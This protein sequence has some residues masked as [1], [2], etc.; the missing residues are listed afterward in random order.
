MDKQLDDK[1]CS[2]FPQLFR[3]RHADKMTTCMYWGFECDSGWEPLI[4]GLSVK[5]QFLSDV[6]GVQVIAKQVKNKLGTLRFYVGV[7]SENA[8]PGSNP[9]MVLSI[10]EDLCWHVLSQS[11]Y[12]CEKCGEYGKI[13]KLPWIQPLCD[14]CYKETRKEDNKIRDSVSRA[15]KKDSE[16]PP[17]KYEVDDGFHPE[18]DHQGNHWNSGKA[19]N[20]VG[21]LQPI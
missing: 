11:A 16:L 21:F 2:D 9:D 12:Y 20:D 15:L 4:R 5:L 14:K 19:E 3:E 18:P 10:A 8:K 6:T 13:R 1:L 7:D 17:A